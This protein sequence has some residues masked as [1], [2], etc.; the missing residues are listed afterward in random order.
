MQRNRLQLLG[1]EAA[2]ISPRVMAFTTLGRMVIIPLC[3]GT[4]L[5]ALLDLLPEG[6]LVRVGLAG[7]KNLLWRRI[8]PVITRD[9]CSP[10]TLLC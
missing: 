3:H 10:R 4:L 6:H 7:S 8:A 2:G 9:P 5:Y 1:S